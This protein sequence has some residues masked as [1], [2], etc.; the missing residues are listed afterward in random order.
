VN[1]HLKKQSEKQ[2]EQEAQLMLTNPRDAMLDIN[3]VR[4]VALY[5]MQCNF[6]ASLSQP[7]A[8]VPPYRMKGGKSIGNSKIANFSHIHVFCAPAEG[9]ALGIGYRRKGDGALQMVKKFDDIFIR[10]E[11]DT[12][13]TSDGQTDRQTDTFRRQKPRYAECHA[14]KNKI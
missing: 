3:R 4:L 2:S 5:L 6:P 8:A 1:Y 10:F 14:G 9:V 7:G 12:I 11:L 13:P